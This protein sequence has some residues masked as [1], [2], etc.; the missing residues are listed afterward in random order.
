MGSTVDAAPLIPTIETL[1]LRLRPYR[2]DDFEAYAAMW[3]DPA[4]VRYI[5]GVPFSRE[6]AWTRFLRQIGLW[7]L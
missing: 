7:Q 6:A 2:L 3:G 1:R 4:V 5:G